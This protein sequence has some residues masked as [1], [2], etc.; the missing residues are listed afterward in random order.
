[1][2]QEAP[3]GVGGS[4]GPGGVGGSGRSSS[5]G[6]LLSSSNTSGAGTG[7]LHEMYN[8]KISYHK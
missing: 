2:A 7:Q 6:I 1:V 5:T 8:H 3:G 4:G